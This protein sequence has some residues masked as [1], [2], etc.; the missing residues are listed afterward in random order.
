MAKKSKK[1]KAP[2]RLG[3][4][5]CGGISG[6]HGAGLLEHRALVTVMAV[7]DIDPNAMK[8]RKA[9]IQ[10]EAPEYTDWKEMLAKEGDNIDAALICLPHDLHAP[11]IVDAC[12]AGKHILCEKPLCTTVPDAN[13]IEKAVK[14]AGVTYMS[15]HNQLFMPIVAEM[16]AL[17]ESGA[18]GRVMF[19]RSQDCFATA[20]TAEEWSWRGKLD[21]QGGGELI[22][23]GYHPTYRLYHLA[24]A[25]PLKVQATFSRFSA[26]IEGED[27][28]SVHILFENGVIGE[29]CT[30]WAMNLAHGTHHLHVIG[31]KGEVFG[32][33]SD[34]WLKP[35]G[36]AEPAHR[37]LPNVNTFVEQMKCFAQCLIN[38][39]RPPHSVAEGRTVLDIILQATKSADG[40]QAVASGKGEKS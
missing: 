3:I 34:L 18:L 21:S 39:A 2:V 7:S 19:V 28:A 36:Y 12:K 6:A 8:G 37:R 24:G 35:D 16:K 1:V 22:D 17:I 26:P 20:R 33:S 9:Q 10:S 31:D 23:T 13:K 38:G 4:I 27:T 15:A 14:A 30:S 5:G 29:I 25:E 40:W 11:A 32:S